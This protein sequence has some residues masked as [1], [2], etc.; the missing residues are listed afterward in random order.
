VSRSPVVPRVPDWIGFCASQRAQIIRHVAELSQHGRIAEIASSGMTGA[1]EPTA[2]LMANWMF[3]C[4]AIILV[5]NYLPERKPLTS[6][7]PASST[8]EVHNVKDC[9]TYGRTGDWI[10]QRRFR[11]NHRPRWTDG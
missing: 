2:Q 3:C 9:S 11:T 5:S 10:G 4:A 7:D 1:A 8:K 6:L